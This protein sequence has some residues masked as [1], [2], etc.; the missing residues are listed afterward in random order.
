[1]DLINWIEK[2]FLF[3]DDTA[4]P[5][6]SQDLFFT[7]IYFWLFMAIVMFFMWLINKSKNKSLLVSIAVAVTFG[8]LFIGFLNPSFL[9]VYL[10]WAFFALFFIYYSYSEKISLS[11]NTFLFATSLFFYYKSGGAFF[12]ILVFTTVLNYFLGL[13]IYGAK[14]KLKKKILVTVSVVINLAVLGFFKYA[15]FFSDSFQ[16]FLNTLN[17]VFGYDFLTQWDLNLVLEQWSKESLGKGFTFS[18]IMLPVGISFFT[19]QAMSYTIDIY[20]DKLK[21]LKNMMHFGFYVSFF[22]QLIMGPIVRAA[23]FIPQIYKPYKLTKVQF[24]TAIFWILNGLLKKAFLADFLANGF[25][26]YSFQNPEMSSGFQCLIAIFGYSLQVYAD[27]SGYT[28]MAIGI[29]LLLGFTFKQNFNSPYKA[30]NVGDFWKRWHISLSTWLRDYLYI[31]LGGSKKGSLASYLVLATML[32]IVLLISK[33]YWR[34]I[35]LAFWWIAG[36]LFVLSLIF[37]KVKS[38]VNTNVNLMIT[39]LLGGL[40][41][42]ASWNMIIWGGLNGLGLV[43]YKLWRK[44]SPYEKINSAWSNTLKIVLTLTFI[45]FTRIFFRSNDMHIYITYVDRYY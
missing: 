11:R 18:R 12:L 38:W 19:F 40:W 34:Y 2:I 20:R 1:M 22:P 7:K 28:D 4:T 17:H 9:I 32:I 5:G 36:T 26:D 24:G 41:H 43:V 27:F 13:A 44:I 29:G 39:M 16:I 42:G 3:N 10:L 35:L 8:L 31:P 37:E 30:R 6:L 25:I 14:Q 45:S 15:Y 23:D 33:E 21:P